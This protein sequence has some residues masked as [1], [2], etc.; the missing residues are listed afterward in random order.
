MV[1]KYS[2]KDLLELLNKILNYENVLENIKVFQSI[3]WN[4]AKDGSDLYI[5]SLFEEDIMLDLAFDLD[6]F[7]QNVPKKDKE[8]GIKDINDDK[9][10]L[11]NL[12][13]VALEE[14]TR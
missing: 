12:V 3:M 5:L 1:K 11:I 2:K 14:L 6:F 9:E 10:E 13:K 8:S 7:G 4:D